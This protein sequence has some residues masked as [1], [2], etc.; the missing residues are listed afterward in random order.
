MLCTDLF[1]L[2]IL[3]NAIT[4]SIMAILSN[5]EVNSLFPKVGHRALFKRNWE[6][7]KRDMHPFVGSGNL[8]SLQCI[9][10]V[11]NSNCFILQKY[12]CNIFPTTAR[13]WD[14]IV[15]M[16]LEVQNVVIVVVRAL[17]GGRQASSLY[18]WTGCVVNRKMKLFPSYTNEIMAEN[19]TFTRSMHTQSF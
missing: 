11:I 2:F 16:A 8:V 15:K 13:N 19:V 17:Q 3:E 6:I 14:Y 12:R 1:Y 9:V 7:W 5:D 18:C 4:S 10:N